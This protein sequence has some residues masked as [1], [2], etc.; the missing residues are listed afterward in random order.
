[1]R[2]HLP[3]SR[4]YFRGGLST[5]D[6]FWAALSPLLAL[7]VRGAY[8]LSA[9]GAATA[10]LYC[11]ISFVF[12]LITFLAFRLND[13][14]SR[15]FSVHDAINILKASAVAGLMTAAVLFTFTRLEGIPRSTPLIYVF[16][17]AAG[18]I[19]ARVL[20][21]L[22]D[23]KNS[24]SAEVTDAPPEHIIMIGANHLSALYIKLV[25]SYSPHRHKVIAVIDDE[26]SLFGRRVVGVPVVSTIAHIDR[27]IEEFEVHGVCVNR[28]IVGGDDTLLA[29]DPLAEVRRVCRQHDIELQF[30]PHLIG[31][32]VFKTKPKNAATPAL[33][34]VPSFANLPR[35]HQVKRVIDFIISAAAIVVLSPL[36]A[37]ISLLVLIDVG[38]PVVFWQQRVGR[39]GSSFFLYKFR[40]LHPPFDRHGRPVFEGN[41]LSWIGRFLRNGRFD[42]LPQLFNVLVGEMSLIGPRPLLPEDQPANSKGRLWARPGVTGWAQINGGNLVTNDEK[43]ALDEW[44]VR[45]ASPWLDLRIIGLTLRFA[46]TGERRSEPAL[47]QALL[48]QENGHSWKKPVSTRK[49]V[50]EE[51]GPALRGRVA[52]KPESIKISAQ[53]EAQSDPLDRNKDLSAGHR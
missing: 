36:I 45:H 10:A 30:V 31:L 52:S 13:G 29:K 17:L 9:E 53:P 12:A 50:R 39:G 25:R 44:Y 3:S 46:F 23:T 4:G 33:K 19:T 16:I 26:L 24:V 1:M 49:T 47:K 27:T 22:R 11:G 37:I 18:L 51:L 48:A 35:Y 15:Y 5:F 40:T 14:L 21:V 28:I 32:D 6:T 8:I 41:R 20:A 43:G 34:A 7:Y 38:S 2:I 42:E